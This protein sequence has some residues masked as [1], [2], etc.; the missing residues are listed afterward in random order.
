[1]VL[2]VHEVSKRYG[3]EEVFS[4]LNIQ[5]GRGE[6]VGIFGDSGA[7][8]ST[9]IN[10]LAGLDKVTT[11]DIRLLGMK[12]PSLE[13]MKRVGYMEQADALYMELTA[14][15][16]M[17]YFGSLYGLKGKKLKQRIEDVAE[18]VELKPYLTN[19][20]G[21]LPSLLKHRLTLAIAL[22]HEPD[23]LILDEPTAMMGDE[24]SRLFWQ[25]LHSWKEQG[26]TIIFTTSLIEEK[27]ICTRFGVIRDGDLVGADVKQMLPKVNDPNERAQ[28]LYSV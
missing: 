16:N 21:T 10:L 25:E 28:V 17:E 23:V 19:A 22:L 5:I 1:M 12:L 14:Y 13:I 9:L 7:G 24:Q 8:K 20:V 18:L 4:G 2:T 3:E 27:E 6:I 11:G 15:G 26:K